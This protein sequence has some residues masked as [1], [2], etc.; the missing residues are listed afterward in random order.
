MAA[1]RL[2]L[3]FFLSPFLRNGFA[4]PLRLSLKRGGVGA[5]QFFEHPQFGDNNTKSLR[6]NW[7]YRCSLLAPRDGVA[8]SLN[9]RDKLL[10]AVTSGKGQGDI[11]EMACIASPSRE[12]A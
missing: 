8:N 4:Q 5:L 9:G 6:L 1:Q 3:W 12:S 7:M 10:E 2:D 11:H